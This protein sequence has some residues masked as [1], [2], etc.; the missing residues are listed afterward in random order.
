LFAATLAGLLPGWLP[1]FG[2]PAESA[3]AEAFWG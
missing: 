1:P 2:A 3:D